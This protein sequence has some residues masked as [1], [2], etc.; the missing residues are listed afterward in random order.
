LS[1]NKNKEGITNKQGEHKH[2]ISED[3]IIIKLASLI[4][5]IIQ[6]NKHSIYLMLMIKIYSTAANV[7]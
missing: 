3:K 7:Q 5:G 1:E 4:V 6:I 2:G